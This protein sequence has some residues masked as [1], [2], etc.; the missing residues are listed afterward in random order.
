M[1]IVLLL[2]YFFIILFM[3]FGLHNGWVLAAMVLGLTVGLS[4]MMVGL[5]IE[6]IKENWSE[7]RCDLDVIMTGFLY[8]QGS[9]ERS[10]TEFMSEN[11][12]FCIKD[13]V[14]SF[15]KILM[16]PVFSA[17]NVQLNL[18]EG[19]VMIMN[20]L[21]NLKSEMLNSFM[22]IITP[23]YQRF[24]NTGMAFSLNFQRFYSAMRRVAGIAVASL[25]LGMSVHVL[26]DN[27]IK[28]VVKIVLIIMGIIA[29]LLVIMFFGIVPF[30]GL[31]IAVVVLLDQAGFDTLG[32]GSVFCF[33]PKT[34]IV[35]F[36]KTIKPIEKLIVG[37]QLEDGGFVQGVLRSTAANEQI[38]SVRGILVSGS[39]LVYDEEKDEWMPVS[40][41]QF[42]E[43][44]FSKPETLICLRTS[45]RNIPIRDF[46]GFKHYFRDWEELPDKEGVDGF[47]N[48]LVS[49]LIKAKKT[50]IPNEDPL[51]GVRCE[52]RLS[53][54]EK[55]P[56][57]H[58]RIGDSVY[59]EK[60]FTKVLGVYEGMASISS[61]KGLTDGVWIKE[62]NEWGHMNMK[63]SEVQ[64]GYH[65]VTQAG[66]FWIES[67]S[68]S[69]CIRDF[70]EVGLDQ[71]P[72]TYSFTRALL[73]KS[74]SKEELC[75]LDSSLPV[76]S[77]YWQLIF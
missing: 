4:F 76:S 56:I 53:T 11:F 49:K 14:Q 20:V 64:R 63:A 74:Q 60:G 5:D 29:G 77:F 2:V 28:F 54:G 24:I 35:L 19:V 33:D 18:A 39:H 52:V 59:S 73:K 31:L 51:C 68:Y 69:G 6:A 62:G 25:Y 43:P 3:G 21:R 9:D 22:K 61:P 50:A 23:M 17:F 71:L 38:Y 36:D 16:T 70:T 1:S 13:T 55:I 26:L 44:I 10:A 47:W 75:E 67:D 65:L 42:A 34:P 7:K 32:M 41:Y 45:T 72:L 27:F 58:V 15:L 48:Y 46:Y 30:L 57:A 66:T 12:Q 8:K 37:D 40:E